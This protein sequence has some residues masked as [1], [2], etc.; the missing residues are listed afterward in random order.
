MAVL[1]AFSQFLQAH[2]AT[3]PHQQKKS[4]KPDFN[5]IMQKQ[6]KYVFPIMIFLFSF[7]LPAAVALYWTVM[8]CFAIVHE[9]IVRR[10]A[11]KITT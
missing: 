1:A 3:P 11:E 7:K 8:N 5:E 4:D 10:R 6:M 9:A 2:L